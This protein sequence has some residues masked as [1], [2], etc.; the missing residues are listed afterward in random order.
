MQVLN[1]W[2]HQKAFKLKARTDVHDVLDSQAAES[3]SP[4]K[5]ILRTVT[6]AYRK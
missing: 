6:E 3:E 2:F 1:V 5:V 4:A